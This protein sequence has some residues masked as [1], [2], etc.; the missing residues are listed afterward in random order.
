MDKNMKTILTILDSHDLYGKELSNIQVYKTLKEYQFRVI[1]AYNK[2]ASDNLIEEI[3]PYE[4]ITVSFPRQIKKKHRIL[5]YFLYFFSSNYQI[6]KII[7]KKKPDAI[8]IPTEIALLYLLPSL[9]FFYK[10]KLIFRIGDAPLLY[11]KQH[12]KYLCKIY[13]VIW[14]VLILKRIDIT[15]S[16][17]KFIQNKLRDSGRKIQSKNDFIIYNL[18]PERS[19]YDKLNLYPN[20]TTTLKLG[21]IGRI[22]EDKGLHLL[23]QATLELLNEGYDI[24]LFIAGNIDKA[25]KYFLYISNIITQTNFI[26]K[27]HFIGNINDIKSFYEAIDISC[28]PSIYEEPLGNILVEAKKYSRPSIIFNVGGMPEL[29]THKHNG[30]ICQTISIQNIKEAITYYYNNRQKIKEEGNN[31]HLSIKELGIDSE[32]FKKKWIKIFNSL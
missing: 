7:S 1:V 11:R 4:K 3:K 22:V 24:E 18:P 31:A 32:Q 26:N 17:S 15:V 21:F 8:L 20:S 27:F 6:S 10:T 2:Y 14:R 16:I 13:N 19:S 9:L 12:K 23:V 5:H 30:Y 28:A 25:D 29:I